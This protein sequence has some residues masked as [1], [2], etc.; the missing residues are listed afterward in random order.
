MVTYGND[1]GMDAIWDGEWKESDVSNGG[2]ERG[3]VFVECGKLHMAGVGSTIQRDV[4]LRGAG[5]AILQFEVS[6][7]GAIKDEPGHI[8][9][10][11]PGGHLT[12]LFTSPNFHFFTILMR[13]FS[14]Q[15]LSSRV[16][17]FT[18]R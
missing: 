10:T 15:A 17:S 3:Q 2:A 18:F 16:T 9:M 8:F 5:Q 12:L 7:K 13:S 14:H 4:D 1:D 6:F 11:S